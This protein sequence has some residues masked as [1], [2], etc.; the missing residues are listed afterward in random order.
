MDAL[1]MELSDQVNA[2]TAEIK[3]IRAAA[4]HVLDKSA[5]DSTE[6]LMD[7]DRAL[8]KLQIELERIAPSKLLGTLPKKKRK[9]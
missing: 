7:L 1:V 8:R 2:L 5:F 6:D 3:R 4:Q 9:P